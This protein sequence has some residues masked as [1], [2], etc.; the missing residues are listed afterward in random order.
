MGD[1]DK[2]VRVKAEMVSLLNKKDQV[3]VVKDR[4]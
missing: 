2:I 1:N 4:F 3:Q